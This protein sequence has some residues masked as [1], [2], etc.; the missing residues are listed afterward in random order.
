MRKKKKLYDTESISLEESIRITTTGKS[1]NVYGL[2]FVQF[3]MLWLGMF[4]PIA[5]FISSFELVYSKDIFILASIASAIFY[6]LIFYFHRYLKITL[7]LTFIF[8][9]YFIW[10]NKILLKNGFYHIENAVIMKLN[11]YL[12]LS[13]GKY[14][15]D[16][17]EEECITILLIAVMQLLGIILSIAIVR[18]IR[19]DVYVIFS[20]LFVISGFM[21]GEVPNPYALLVY[22]IYLFMIFAMGDAPFRRQLFRKYKSSDVRIDRLDYKQL[23]RL[24]VA[25]IMGLILCVLTLL[26]VTILSPKDYEEYVDFSSTKEEIQSA[27]MDFSVEDATEGLRS[28]LENLNPFTGSSGLFRSDK[29]LKGG[30]DGGRLGAAASVEF[31]NETALKLT[32]PKASGSLYLKG[33]AGSTYVGNAWEG[34]SKEETSNYSHIIEEYGSD[35]LSGESLSNAY[36]NLFLEGVIQYTPELLF[37]AGYNPSNMVRRFELDVDYVSAN[38]KFM[39][40]PYFLDTSQLSGVSP[41]ADLYLKPKKRNASYTFSYYK[42]QEGNN[43][44]DNLHKLYEMNYMIQV[45]DKAAYEKFVNFEREYRKFVY[46][47]Y[48]GIPEGKFKRIEDANL[49]IPKAYDTESMLFTVDEVT[50]YLSNNTRYTLSP[51]ALPKG[52]D[53]IEYFLFDS[54]KGYCAHYASSAVMLLRYF[55]VPARYIEGYIVTEKD[56]NQGKV[57]EQTTFVTYD[58]SLETTSE[59]TPNMTVEI[60]D[61]NAHAWIEVYMDG[62][63]WLPVEVTA[64]YSEEGIDS[65]NQSI[66]R[67][68]SGIPTSTPLPTNTP[69]PT[70]KPQPTITKEPEITVTNTPIPTELESG[71]TPSVSAEQKPSITSGVGNQGAN[72]LEENSKRFGLLSIVARILII[73][74]VV[75]ALLIGRFLVLQNTRNK[76]IYH[77]KDSNAASIYIYREI[78]RMLY[79][80]QFQ[81]IEGETYED[82]F[83]RVEKDYK[84]IPSGFSDMVELVLKARF[85]NEKLDKEELESVLS[86]YNAFREKFYE[87]L[88]PLRRSYLKYWKVL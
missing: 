51:G 69:K 44:M 43:L 15:A 42:L 30:L 59:V 6:W 66:E 34:L 62:I 50:K 41:I 46:D 11:D 39:Y 57:G 65:I 84:Q 67:R 38:E 83:K 64:G 60:R 3:L 78:E 82:F 32:M 81:K 85:S 36:L 80:L 10:K 2:Y 77:A 72:S 17:N 24:K 53:F 7:P 1:S 4:T 19:K 47:T 33:F 71:I 14:K 40:A 27:L 70:Q 75:V 8:V 35:G 31:T 56:I 48:V 88:K 55:G 9:G 26:L 22:V 28:T 20:L 73:I 58:A 13:I 86:Y 16:F 87:Q 74:V 12:D 61:A 76:H 21:I 18:E 45:N 29:Y 37:N 5:C 68:I 23:L 52:E 25:S 79:A 54:K 63:G 49:P